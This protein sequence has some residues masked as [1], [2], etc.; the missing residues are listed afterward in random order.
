MSSVLGPQTTPMAEGVGPVAI[1]GPSMVRL[2]ALS[3]AEDHTGTYSIQTDPTTLDF[4]PLLTED[5][6]LFCSVILNKAQ[7]FDNC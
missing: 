1:F 3:P 7:F 4:Q 6:V 5:R 2:L